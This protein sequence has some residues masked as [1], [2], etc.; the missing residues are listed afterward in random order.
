ML[1]HMDHAEQFVAILITALALGVLA[2]TIASHVAVE[3]FHRHTEDRLQRWEADLGWRTGLLSGNRALADEDIAT[4]NQLLDERAAELR[5]QGNDLRIR[6]E[7]V[8]AAEQQLARKTAETKAAL[9]A[10]KQAFDDDTTINDLDWE[11]QPELRSVLDDTVMLP[12]IEEE[13]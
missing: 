6:E 9:H 5:H 2:G 3:Y 10:T 13:L 12:R 7:A 8:S 1:A 11:K 4:R